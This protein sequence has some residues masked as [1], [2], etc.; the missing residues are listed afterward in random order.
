[1]KTIALGSI[2]RNST[3]YLDRYFE[4]VEAL[5]NTL[6]SRGDSLRLIL[7]EGDSTDN[8]F[9]LLSEKVFHGEKIVEKREH[10]GPLFGSVDD[11]IRW[12]NSSYVWN[13]VMEHVRATDDE[14]IYVESDLIW[15]ADTMLR[16]LQLL[17]SHE[18]IDAVAPM[19]FH[20]SGFMYDTY[21]HRKDGIRFSPTPPYHPGVNGD[22]TEIDSAGSCLVMRGLVARNARFNPPELGIVGF[23]Q[24][25]RGRGFKL[26]LAPFLK[27]LHP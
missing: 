19:C 1:M 18:E 17:E 5:N 26:W 4:Q 9:N 11:A 24:D 8:T 12:R 23:G 21:G 20:V 13:G 15:D 6:H 3:P 25:I 16:L 10:H 7:L 14:F 22:L 2:F 27:V